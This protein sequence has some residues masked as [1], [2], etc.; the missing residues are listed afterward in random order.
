MLRSSLDCPFCSV[1]IRI[2]IVPSKVTPKRSSPRLSAVF[3]KEIARPGSYGD[4]RGGHGLTLRVKPRKT[5]GFTKHWVQRLRVYGKPVNIGLGPYPLISLA[6]ARESA[7]ANRREAIAGRDPRVRADDVPTFSQ[8]AEAVIALRQQIWKT[9]A[10]EARIWRSGFRDYVNPTLGSK[11]VT[12]ISTDDLLTILTPIWQ[13]RQETA[14]RLTQRISTVMRWCVAKGFRPDNPAGEAI[15]EALPLRRRRRRH[16]RA[17]HYRDVTS[18][19]RTV[20]HSAA[21]RA[22]I[23]C[24]EFLVLT[25]TRNSEARQAR[26][27]HIHFADAI[28]TIPAEQM[29]TERVHRVPLSTGSL[30]VLREARSIH[31]ETGWLFPSVTGQPLSGRTLSKLMTQLNIAAVPHGFRASFRTWA[32]E[33]TDAPRAVMEAALA[34]AV[35]DATERAYAR[36]DL[37]EK[38][39]LLM[40]AWSDYLC[41]T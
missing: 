10:V 31:D 14:R 30:D 8:A 35:G 27:D 1:A 41:G 4:G 23:L 34:H 25:A 29:K 28:W 36:S 13:D 37:F 15:R 12:K 9:G 26:W 2:Q 22:T 5:G 11:R 38:R 18:A 21:H 39:R 3:C 6:A 7:L 19:L 20:R 24:F 33:Q 40:Q 17:L 16:Y 32:Q